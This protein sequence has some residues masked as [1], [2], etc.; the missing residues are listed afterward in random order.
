MLEGPEERMT[1]AV[2]SPLQSQADVVHFISKC[3]SDQS[4]G[5]KTDLNPLVLKLLE[6]KSN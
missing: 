5:L 3:N 6:R 2:A 1:P 4:E